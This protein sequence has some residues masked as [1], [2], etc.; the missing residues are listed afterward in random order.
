MVLIYPDVVHTIN[1]VTEIRHGSVL[2]DHHKINGI[3]IKWR[4]HHKINGKIIKRRDHRKVNGV[5]IT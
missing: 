4:H 2:H 5:V 3:I 1:C